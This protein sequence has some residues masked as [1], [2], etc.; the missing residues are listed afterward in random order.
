MNCSRLTIMLALV[1]HT[2]AVTAGPRDM[3]AKP[4]AGPRGGNPGTP[5]R[6]AA[7]SENSAAAPDGDGGAGMAAA[8]PGAVP[9]GPA[10]RPGTQSGTID[11]CQRY[12][13][14]CDVPAENQAQA[15]EI[16]GK[17]NGFFDYGLLSASIDK[18]REALKYWNH[19]GIHYNLMAALVGLDRPLE[20][21][22]SSV[23]ALRYGAD[24]FQSEREYKRATDHQKRLLGRLVKVHVRCAEEGAVVSLDGKTLFVGPG[25]K[26][27]MILPGHHQLMA[28]KPGYLI[29]QESLILLPGWKLSTELV[30]LPESAA[31]LS[32][33]R[34][35]QWQPHAA[36]AGG[37]AAVLA[38]GLLQWRAAAANRAFTAL[39][40][41]EC[42]VPDGCFADGY[43]SE[44]RSL[45]RRERW[46]GGISTGLYAA[47]AAALVAGAVLTYVNRSREIE[48][49]LRNDL[50]R[51]SLTPMFGKA[52]GPVSDPASGQIF[53]PISVPISDPMFAPVPAS[54][55]AEFSLSFSF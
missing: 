9:A 24:A 38:G 30:M 31:T 8:V 10:V 51:V 28:R 41:G 40:N 54:I 43:T 1:I 45:E 37:T 11:K 52:A 35:K 14:Y 55:G 53:D 15:I 39:F 17:G 29:S 25:E 23:E 50:V 32:V 22:E 46:Y 12:P 33:R 26:T 4:V 34:W 18:Y 20:A 36:T 16:Y 6:L 44:M 49:P 47:G 13:W 27:L 5:T 42:A 19:P 3:P 21:Y 48:N 7:E 2:G